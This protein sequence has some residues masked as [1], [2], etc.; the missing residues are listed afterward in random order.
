MLTLETVF[1][2]YEG[3]R[4]AALCLLFLE[5]AAAASWHIAFAESAA[6]HGADINFVI[7]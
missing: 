5:S 4:L 1:A 2:F 3:E 7:Q 6:I